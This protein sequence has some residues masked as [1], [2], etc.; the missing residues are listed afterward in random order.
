MNSVEFVALSKEKFIRIICVLFPT[1][2]SNNTISTVTQFGAVRND[3]LYRL[4]LL[5]LRLVDAWYF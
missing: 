5:N 3:L 1:Q 2:K 4:S